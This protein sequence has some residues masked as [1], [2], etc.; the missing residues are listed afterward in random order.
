V[1]SFDDDLINS[2]QTSTIRQ[3]VS[4]PFEPRLRQPSTDL[5][6]LGDQTDQ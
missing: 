1:F 2:R 5:D 4:I 6:A 3:A